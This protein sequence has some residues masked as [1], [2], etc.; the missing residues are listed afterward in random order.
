MITRRGLINGSALAALGG[1]GGLGGYAFAVEP[2]FRLEVARYK[3][4]PPGWPPGLQLR[5][6]ALADIHAAEPWMDVDRIRQIV[7]RANALEPDVALLLGDYAGGVAPVSGD[8]PPEA[9]A[10]A[11]SG[12]RAR[13]GI[14]AVLGNHDW[15]RDPMAAFA[16]DA[17]S[18]PWRALEAAGI[19]VLENEAVRI[20]H[21]GRPVWIAGLGDQIVRQEGRERPGRDDLPKTLAA[22]GPAEEPAL[23]M[24]HEPDIF[25]HVP[26]RIALTLSG[27]THGGQVRFFGRAPV[28]PSR[29]GERY[30][31]GH[32]EEGGRHLVVSG[33][34]GC[35][36]LPV[37]FG[38]P[39]EIVM[40][41][42]GE[43]APPPRE[44]APAEEDGA[45]PPLFV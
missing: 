43:K 34:L 6:V 22:L 11:L 20:V 14:F 19:R 25:P 21:R 26:D 32:I 33:G 44:E 30:A 40:V 36:N 42:L 8:V 9:W 24:A 18:V 15:G 10:G 28:V 5:I 35:S 16:G 1:A 2:G 17:R 37:R 7:A 38:A 45:R 4:T 3:L 12:L 39:P 31:Y 29:Y 41:E 27:H 13:R 23:L